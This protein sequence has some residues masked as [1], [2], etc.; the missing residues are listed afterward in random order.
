MV[1]PDKWFWDSEK[2]CHRTILMVGAR[3]PIV[4]LSAET[5]VLTQSTVQIDHPTADM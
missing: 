5:L 4:C 1:S 2:G 3:G